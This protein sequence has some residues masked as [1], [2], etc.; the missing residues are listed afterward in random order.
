MR[1]DAVLTSPVLWSCPSA[2]W[3]L[4]A[5]CAVALGL[6]FLP[7]LQRLYGLWMTRE[8]YSFGVLVPFIAAFLLWQRRGELAATRFEAS[9]L[10][11]GVLGAGLA[12]GLLGRISTLDTL[13]QYAF[14]VCLAGV[15]LAFVGRRALRIVAA[16]LAMLA[17]MLPLPE[18]LLRELSGTLQLWSSELGAWLIRLAGMSVYLEGNVIDLGA[19]KLQVVEACSGLRYLLPLLTLGFITAYFFRAPLW[20][21]AL[22][23]AS[24]APITLLMN[25][26]RIALIG[27]TA[28]HFGR[29]AAEGFLHDFEGWAV[30]MTCMAVLFLEMALFARMAGRRLRE[31]FGIELPPRGPR[32]IA[33]RVR[34]LPTTLAVAAAILVT[35]TLLQVLVPPP[36]SIAP[37]RR[38]FAEFPL[39]LGAWQGRPERMET[40][41]LET[42]K[43]DDYLIANFVDGARTAVNL[44]IG[45]HASQRDGIAVHSPRDCL[46]ADGWEMRSFERHA[47]AGVP[48]LNRVVIQ[49]GET[50]QLVYYWFQQ[51]DRVVAGEYA[52]KFY[53]FWDLVNR[54]RSDGALVRLV[55]PIRPGEPAGAAD[56]RLAAFIA[57][58]A[59]RL[60]AFVP[61]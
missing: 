3:G 45:Y 18:L 5:V 24:A 26:A 10:G 50:R 27:L 6:L 58:L 39:Q 23:V 48:E 52:V 16:P 49:K 19:M 55:T 34:A 46:P 28:E 54:Q 13:S 31:V 47:V 20:Q 51:R 40:A 21:R 11:V 15:V 60:P 42:L 9:W 8:E 59:P 7:P 32:A 36:A 22:L 37:A 14:L 61:G 17:F 2:V 25:S 57:E 12:L 4:L 33:V 41:Y 44:Y 1:R 43:L 53:L 29:A 30:F 38:D 56:G 35:A